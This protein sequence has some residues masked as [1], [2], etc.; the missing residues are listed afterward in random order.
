MIVKFARYSVKQNVC[1]CNNRL[2]GKTLSINE[3]LTKLRIGKLRAGRD[4]YG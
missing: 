3:I 1:N 2:K 4:K